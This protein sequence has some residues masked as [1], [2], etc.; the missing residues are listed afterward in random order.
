MR[1]VQLLAAAASLLF[2]LNARPARADG[3]KEQCAAA[4][5]AGQRM[6]MVG[7]LQR[8]IEEFESCA[9]SPCSVPAQRE[10]K[11]LLEAAQAA[12]PTVQFEL[13]FG[14]NLAK[15]PV[16]LSIDDREPVAYGG[17]T[18]SVN[19]GKHRFVFECDGCAT[20]TRR[21]EFADHDLK[22]KEVA[23]NPACGNPDASTSGAASA[24][25]AQSTNCPVLGASA[26]AVKPKL[27]RVPLLPLRNSTADDTRLRDTVIFASAAALATVGGIGFVGFGL[28]AR[29]GERALT[30]CAPYCSDT[31]IAAVK[32]N[33]LLANVSLGTG[34]LAI[35]GA[36]IWWFGLRSASHSAA[37]GGQ[38]SVALGPISTLRRTF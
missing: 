1:R 32:R 31:Q 6:Q 20:V 38:W 29:S 3:A 13:R 15:R 24:P 28:T 37:S 21:I 22:H 26:A 34:L 11:R 8:A 36:T 14:A 35:G 5:E 33:Y 2:V 4:F 30:E 27:G 19:A 23:L 17:E 10:C 18:L 25:R 7:D 9:E 12:I 16:M